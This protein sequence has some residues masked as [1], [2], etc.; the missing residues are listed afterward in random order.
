[1]LNLYIWRFTKVSRNRGAIMA[2]VAIDLFCGAGGT[3]KGLCSVGI[4]VRAGVEIDPIASETYSYNNPGTLLINDDIKNISGDCLI[5]SINLNNHDM[6]LLVACPPC[7]GFSSIGKGDSLDERNFLIFEYLRLIDEI[8]PPFILMENVSGIIRKKENN[9]FSKFIDNLKIEYDIKYEIL[10]AADYGVPQIRKRMVLHGVR[11][12]LANQNNITISLPQP[13][14]SKHGD[15]LLRQWN[16]VNVIMDLPPLCAGEAYVIDEGDNP[17]VIYNHFCNNLSDINLRRIRYIR[18]HGG[19]RSCLPEELVLN[20]HKKISGHGDVYGVLALDK[21]SVTITAG[22]MSYTKGRFGH[23]TQDR[24]LSAREAARLQS[25]PDNYNF[26]GNK[27]QIARQIGN[28]V[29]VELSAASGRYFL[30]LYNQLR[31]V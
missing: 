15:K 21:P 29:P 5:D 23:P 26:L 3:T 17:R 20:C 28:A 31:G 19:S 11:R 12:D 27:V 6:L 9:I 2:L 24:A 13:T 16:T 1:M 4:D 18:E 14:H 30:D 10:N 8:R 22:C 7:Q 25:F